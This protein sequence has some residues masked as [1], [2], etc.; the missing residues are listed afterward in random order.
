[1]SRALQPNSARAATQPTRNP[2]HPR[3]RSGVGFDRYLALATER[4]FHQE[5]SEHRVSHVAAPGPEIDGL[6]LRADDQPNHRARCHQRQK[7]EQGSQK[8]VWLDCEQHHLDT[9]NIIEVYVS[10]P[11][12]GR[13]V[14]PNAVL[15]KRCLR[16]LVRI[17]RRPERV[18]EK[19]DPGGRAVRGPD[20]RLERRLEVFRGFKHDHP[21]PRLHPTLSFQPRV[22][23]SSAGRRDGERRPH[24]RVAGTT[25]VDECVVNAPRGELIM[26]AP[27]PQI[28]R[29]HS[30]N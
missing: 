23:W 30:A 10:G 5:L 14:N 19:V 27:P 6:A 3:D 26:I 20:G 18:A 4:A 25:S 11:V 29:D 7:P 17:V 15:P 22:V 12:V 9:P 24:R 16:L 8:P 28:G 13:E 21:T 2:E 1:M